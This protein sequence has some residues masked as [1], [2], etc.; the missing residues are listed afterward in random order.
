MSGL[1]EDDAGDDEA[2]AESDRKNYYICY[3]D[4]AATVGDNK[5]PAAAADDD[6]KSPPAA[7]DDDNKSPAAAAADNKSP[8]AA[9]ADDDDNK[10]PPAAPADDDNKSPPAPADD[11]D[12]KSPPAAPADDDCE[13]VYTCKSYSIT[14]CVKKVEI[15]KG[16]LLTG[17]IMKQCIE[18]VHTCYISMSCCG[19]TC[20]YNASSQF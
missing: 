4:Y 1:N 5:S 18:S 17:D 2:D 9:A 10:S 14:V 20:A 19:V 16:I 12:N 11:D 3:H 6:N 15:L 7:A 13:I 8:A